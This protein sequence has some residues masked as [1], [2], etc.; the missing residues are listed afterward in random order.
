MILI[1]PCSRAST[2][3]GGIDQPTSTCPLIVWVKVGVGL[4]V[5]TGLTVTPF[6]LARPSTMRLLDEPV[7]EKATV[8][9]AASLKDFIG[10]ADG[11]YQYSYAPFIV[12]PIA[13][14]GAPLAKAPIVC[15]VPTMPISTAPDMIA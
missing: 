14:I 11:T 15:K 7:V 8:L 3:N 2:P 1:L 5:A 10:E 4:P 12:A 9:P 13:R 6:S